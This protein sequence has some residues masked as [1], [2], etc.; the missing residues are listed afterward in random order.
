MLRNVVTKQNRAIGS[1]WIVGGGVVLLIGGGAA[2]AYSVSSLLLAIVGVFVAYIGMRG[3][4]RGRRH[5]VRIG[6]ESLA[7]DQRPPVLYLRPFGYDG[8]DFHVSPGTLGRSA[9]ERGFWRQMG[10][11]MRLIRTSEQLLSRA[12][13]DVGPLVAIGDP[14]SELPRLGAVRVY[15][16]EGLEWQNVVADLAK[17]S[18]YVILEIGLSDG[19]QW[20]VS[21]IAHTV[22]PQKLI[23]SLPSDAKTARR[24]MRPGKRERRRLE[25]YAAF[26]AATVREFPNPLPEKIGQAR[27]IY[28]EADWT[29]RPTYYQREIMVPFGRRIRHPED[30]KLEALIW[31]NSVQ[32]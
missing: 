22:P 25:Y 5:F 26:R 7:D 24:F 14:G 21:F 19:V 32:F 12:F 1:L 2:L 27:Y 18:R 3:V 17:R 20:E 29:P 23:L 28:F 10:V 30:P 31:L 15:A 11:M 13:R 9:I 8:T 6:M 4:N 16:R